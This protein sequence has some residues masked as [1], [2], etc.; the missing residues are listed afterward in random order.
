MVLRAVVIE[1]YGVDLSLSVLVNYQQ[2][3]CRVASF[4][5]CACPG[6]LQGCRVMVLIITGLLDRFTTPDIG[7]FLSATSIE[8]ST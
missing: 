4:L 5:L 8:P 7:R 1:I 3:F 6:S 2:P